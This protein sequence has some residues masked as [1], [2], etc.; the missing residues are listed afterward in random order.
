MTKNINIFFGV[1]Q[2]TIDLTDEEVG[3]PQIQFVARLIEGE[4]PDYQAIIP[5]SYATS[6]VFSKK[7]LL[8]HLKSASLFAGKGNEVNVKIKEKDAAMLI[9]SQSTDLGDYESEM[10]LDKVAGGDINIA[11]NY[12]FLIDGLNS[13]KNDKCV[14]EFSND[15]GPGVLKP[16]SE[17]GFIYILMPIKKY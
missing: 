3:Q 16:E 13:I 17:D 14:F 1:N 5:A 11:F 4:F 9:S 12:R 8:N 6:I 10:K 2:I 15:E 7:E